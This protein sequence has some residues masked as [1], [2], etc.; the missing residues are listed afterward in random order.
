MRSEQMTLS[1]PLTNAS[2]KFTKLP[3]KQIDAVSKYFKNHNKFDF[4]IK[5]NNQI[6]IVLKQH[7]PY[8]AL[9]D[10]ILKRKSTGLEIGEFKGMDFIPSHDFALSTEISENTPSVNLDKNT[11]L[12]YLKKENIELEN[13]APQGWVLAQYEGLNLGWMKVMK[14]RINNYL[15]K[16]FRIRMDLPREN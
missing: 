8:I 7:I 9:I 6:F 5:P 11:A 1:H 16:D 3:K 13:D 4:F 2:L 12:H 10:S 14:N 15:T